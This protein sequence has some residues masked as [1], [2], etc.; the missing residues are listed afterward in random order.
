V[1]TYSPFQCEFDQIKTSDLAVLRTVAEGWYVEY[2]REM[3]EPASIAK[4]I[5]ALANTYGGWLFYGISE[6]SKAEPVAATFGGIVRNEV[7]AA[8]QRIRDAISQ[9]SQPPPH[10][11]ARAL[12]GPDNSIGLEAEHAIIAIRVPWGPQA[13]YV[14]KDGRI[15]RRVSDSS[16]PKLENDRFILDQLWKR[17]EPLR[18]EYKN[19]F[20][21]DPILSKAETSAPLLR[22]L[23]VAD[24]WKDRGL[25]A[26]LLLSDIRDIVGPSTEA[27]TLPFDTV[28]SS[29]NG[30]ICRQI[31][32]NDPERLGLTWRFRNDLRSEV[33]IPLSKYRMN[34]EELAAAFNGYT[35]TERFAELLC[36][37]RYCE[38]TV[39]DL[40]LL[41]HVFL[42]VTHIQKTFMKRAGW[43]GDI[44]A[45]MKLTG[46]WRT[47]PFIDA[48]HV[49][50]YYETHGVPLCLDEAV[51]IY[52]G[53]SMESF[54][55]LL[56]K[57][58]MDDEAH[59]IAM[60][61]NLF[62]HVAGSLGIPLG[63]NPDGDGSDIGP[64][65]RAFLEAGQRAI[66]VQRNRN[67]RN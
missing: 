14:H 21:A 49:L 35:S 67:Q 15:Y 10:F 31:A 13:P 56:P 38:P 2:K 46:V 48:S 9:H 4:S 51:L 12:F 61:L 26:K 8:L 5:T 55:R 40:N 25:Q 27:H 52:R 34:P 54:V 42:G 28:Y 24:I 47:I 3:P 65:I 62:W 57:E 59:R 60:A 45:K 22:L 53:S 63:I 32:D 6:K 7:D 33:I 39:I 29:S 23:L 44:Y 64:S 41:F 58:E 19:W 66:E 16:H 50:E 30:Y 20:D 18:Q 36:K 37:Q 43:N 11:D 1:Q 17:G